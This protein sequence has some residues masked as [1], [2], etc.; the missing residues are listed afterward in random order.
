MY[1]TNNTSRSIE[2]I[3]RSKNNLLLS[4][5]VKPYALLQEVQVAE[6]NKERFKEAAKIWVE[7][8]K[9]TIKEKHPDS[10]KEVEKEAQKASDAFDSQTKEEQEKLDD[11]YANISNTLSDAGDELAGATETGTSLEF[12]VTEATS[13]SKKSK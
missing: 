4:I 2:I 13:K 5:P 9:I 1:I 10:V 6:A 3:Y 11:I 7:A 8:G 12:S